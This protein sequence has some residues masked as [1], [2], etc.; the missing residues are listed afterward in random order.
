[1]AASTGSPTNRIVSASLQ[2]PLIGRTSHSYGRAR[3]TKIRTAAT[4]FSMGPPLS[5]SMHSSHEPADRTQQQEQHEARPKG[6]G[7]GDPEERDQRHRTDEP[8]RPTGQP[9]PHGVGE[10]EDSHQQPHQ[11]DR[12]ELGDERQPHRTEAELAQLLNEI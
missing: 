5:P 2:T 6:D 8:R 12:G 10:E 3:P 1:M 7:G 9:I 4:R 11:S